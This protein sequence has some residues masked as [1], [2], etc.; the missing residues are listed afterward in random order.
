VRR[1]EEGDRLDRVFLVGI[2]LKGLDGL[3]ELVGG[4]LLLFV[5]P[6][7]IDQVARVLTQHE[8]SENPH[9]VLATFVFHA[10]SSLSGSATTFG[11]AYLLSHGVVK[12]V[13]VGALLRNQH[14]AYP[15]MILFLLAFGGYEIYRMTFAPTI[16]LAGLTVF[17]FI[18][19]LL[20]YLEWRRQRIRWRSP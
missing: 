14:W 10:I 18:V 16:W 1:F 13:L 2:V 11:A 6:A 8:L 20:T 5:T 15:W 7:L 3:L 4:L 17:D 9:D 12:I 19:A